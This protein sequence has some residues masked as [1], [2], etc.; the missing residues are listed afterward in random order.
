MRCPWLQCFQI[1]LFISM[2]SV[3][4]SAMAN[5]QVFATRLIFDGN[6]KEA[7]VRIENVSPATA[8]IQ[9]WLEHQKT[10]PASMPLPFFVTPPLSRIEAQQ[11]NIL[12]IRRTGAA[13]PEDREAVFWLN[14]KE[15]PQV[16][17]TENALQ[18]AINTRIKLFFRPANL[19]ICAN[20]AYTKLDWQ[21]VQRESGL[22]LHASNPTP[23]FITLANLVLND[24]EKVDIAATQMLAPFSAAHYDLG[25]GLTQAAEIHQI[26]Y[27]TINDYGGE[28]PTLKVA[29]PNH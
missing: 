18:F 10:T 24:K 21:V 5:I 28:T 25:S 6:K 3:T 16:V 19:A 23:C 11:Q 13:L 27:Q 15:I 4:V 7:S 17:K 8:L 1:A 29:L 9:T 22:A 2:C 12:R 14:I 20:D 26:T